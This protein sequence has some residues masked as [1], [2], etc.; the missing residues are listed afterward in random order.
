MS[1]IKNKTTAIAIFLIAI[2]AVSIVAM[3]NAKAQTDYRTKK[4]YAMCGLMPNPV[5]VGQEVLVWVAITD[6]VQN[7]SCGWTGL[8]VT[9]TKPDGSTELLDNNGAGFRTDATGSTGTVYVPDTAG[10]YTFQTH[11][12]QQWFNWTSPPMFD[13][14]IY[15]NIL[16]LASDSA[17]V[18]LVVQD[19]PIPDYPATPLP[20]EY[21]TRPINAQLYTWNT[22]SANWLNRPTNA[23]AP[24]NDEAPESS[25]IL[26]SKPLATGGLSGGFLGDHSAESGDAYEGKFVGTVIING[27]LYYNR[28]ASGFG[29]GWSQQ[30]IYAVDLRTGEELWFK[31]NSRLAFGQTLYWDSF[32]MHGVFSYIYETVSTFDFATFTSITTW[33]AYDPL[34]GEYEF[35]ISNV[36]TASVMFGATYQRIGPHGE[37]LIYN[38]DLVNGWVAMWNSTTAVIGSP[39]AG[40]MGAGSWGSAANTQRTFDGSRGYDWNYS[41]ADGLAG[42]LPGSITTLQED[43][44]VGCTAGGWTNI[45]DKPVGIW[46]FS[47]KPSAGKL[48]LLFN[49]TWTPPLGDLTPSYGETS[50]ED[51]VFTIEVK[52][53]RQIY[54][55]SLDN[56]QKI[57]GPTEP[58][59]PLNIYGITGAIA[60]GRLFCTGYGGVLYC[61]NVT[62]GDLLWT[63]TASDPYNEILWSTDWPIF[64]AFITDG[65]IYMQHNEHSPVNPLPRGAPFL[66]IDIE[67][68]TA[69][70]NIPL[71]TTSWGG[72][73]VIGD[74]IIA[75]YNSYDSQVYAVGKGPST[76]TVTAPDI[77]VPAGSSVTIRGTVTDQSAGAKDTPA[78][79]DES[80]DAWMLYLYMQFPRPSN[81]TGVAV[82]LDAIDPNNNYIHIG[83]TTS[84]ASGLFSYQWNPPSD[85]PGKYTIIATFAG[86]KSYW[87]SFAETAVS[88]DPA[89]EATPAPTPTPA[90][91]AEMYFVPATAGMIIAVVA[92]GAVIVLMLRK[93]P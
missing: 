57:W 18:T 79:S 87:P 9:V 26:W 36:P 43:R 69:L 82:T 65:K 38:I 32:N 86:S 29:G 19:E 64:V 5:G 78:I 52:E 84:D 34:T 17:K 73:P 30:G 68:G 85:I 25:H 10:N 47:L 56:G 50:L 48:P 4:T 23:Y 70:W 41:L 61:Y 89:A 39:E 88:L 49:T 33:K 72:G 62:T 12:P 83:D 3:P 8:T 59:A 31:N 93:R 55:F 74:S 54:G 51:K 58:Q 67:N 20:T 37:F 27:I 21:W 13:P 28:Y 46:A 2:F 11:F 81:A 14:E 16:Y 44:V 60:Y 6:Y 1:T 92:V 91:M 90:S 66:C 24:N 75:L 53:T 22:I 40:E 7:Q 15:G 80:M 42:N 77:G 35:S 71:R 63:Y 45:G 76:T